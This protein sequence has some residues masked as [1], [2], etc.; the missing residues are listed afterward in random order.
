MAMKLE[1]G[2]EVEVKV[3]VKNVAITWKIL[4]CY[5]PNRELFSP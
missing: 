2:V 5:T 3:E 1:V 4:R